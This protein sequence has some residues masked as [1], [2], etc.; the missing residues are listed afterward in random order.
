MNVTVTI[1][2]DLQTYIEDRVR[3][4]AY[5]NAVDYFLDLVQCDRQRKQAQEK[6]ERLLQE[7]LD[8]DG[9]PVTLAYW[10]EL[11]ASVLNAA[12]QEP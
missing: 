12:P 10:Q 4:G 5:A 8:S 9:E 3:S 2:E 7:G 1:P 6:L 11:R